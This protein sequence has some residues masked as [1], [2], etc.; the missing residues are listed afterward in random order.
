VSTQGRRPARQ[1]GLTDLLE[2]SGPPLLEVPD[3]SLIKIAAFLLVQMPGT[4]W[5][6]LHKGP[7]NGVR[8]GCGIVPRCQI[9]LARDGDVLPR[10]TNTYFLFDEQT[11][12]LV[13]THTEREYTLAEHTPAPGFTQ[14][15]S[16]AVPAGESDTI[17]VCIS[18]SMPI[19]EVGGENPAQWSIMDII[20]SGQ[21]SVQ[22]SSEICWDCGGDPPWRWLVPALAGQKPNATANGRG[23]SGMTCI[24]A[25]TAAQLG[26]QPLGEWDASRLTG[27]TCDFALG[28]GQA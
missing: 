27:R 14:P 3:T 7:H 25:T 10:L 22:M 16:E 26:A 1:I 12:E 28:R 11:G 18:A 17:T 4:P 6:I 8:L 19:I 15:P 9:V 13:V 20:S 23:G 24:D 5:G 2:M 21:C